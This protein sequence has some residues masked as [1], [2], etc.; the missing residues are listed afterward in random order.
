MLN[1]C[2]INALCKHAHYGTCLVLDLLTC[3]IAVC[4]PLLAS[5]QG[6]LAG[7]R[8]TQDTID[9]ASQ[10][11]EGTEALAFDSVY[12]QSFTSQV[13]AP[14]DPTCALHNCSLATLCSP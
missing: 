5:L 6:W 14:S 4:M 8:R 7:C 10:P 1:A 13:G 2:H 12:A 11:K 9:N 3:T